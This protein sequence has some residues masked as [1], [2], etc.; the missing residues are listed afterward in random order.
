MLPP[1]NLDIIVIH[2]G[3]K[4]S[5]GGESL[6]IN[7]IYIVIKFNLSYRRVTCFK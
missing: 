3:V 1:S 5:T 2:R 6:A 7:T 4:L